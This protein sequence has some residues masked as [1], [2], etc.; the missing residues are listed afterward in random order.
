[1]ENLQREDLNPVEEAG[2][3]KVLMG[4][5]GL[6]Q[7]EVAARVGKSRSAVA[8]ALRLLTLPDAVCLLLE[9]GKLS[10]GHARA[11]LSVARGD[12]R[13]LLAQKILDED[14][15][16]RQT[17]AWAKRLN[18]AEEAPD[19]KPKCEDPNRIYRDSAAK[20]L[21]ARLGRRV[22]IVHGAKKGKIELEYYDDTDLTALLD[23]FEQ[24]P[25]HGKGDNLK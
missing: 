25:K 22:S 3:Y 2:G 17:E 11:I 7:E 23:I 8:N 6:T 18:Q 1:I 13:K 14:L 24:L 5:Y 19:D 16:V 21:S 20:A 4:E 15:S 10:A 9:E 12:Q